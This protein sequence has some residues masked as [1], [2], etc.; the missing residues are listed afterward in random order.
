M[1]NLPKGFDSL[2]EAQQKKF[3][4]LKSLKD[5]GGKV[6]GLYCSYVP[7][8]SYTQQK[9]FPFLYVQPVKTT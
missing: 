5:S 8:N 6:I 9:L 2:A 7:P 3:L 1:H 4:A